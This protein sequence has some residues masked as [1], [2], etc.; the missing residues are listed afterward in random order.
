LI[1]Q[2]LTGGL[3]PLSGKLH[4]FGELISDDS[5]NNVRVNYR[6]M[7]GV[8][9]AE[10]YLLSSLTPRDHLRLFLSNKCIKQDVSRID[11]ILK[12]FLLEQY[13][14]IKCKLPILY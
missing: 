3:N 1:F 7:C 6:K 10:D 5:C 12:L 8:V 11:Y 4:I 9:F 13:A 2:C 14:D